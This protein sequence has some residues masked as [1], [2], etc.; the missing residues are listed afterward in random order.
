MKTNFRNTFKS[1]DR[2]EPKLSDG[3]VHSSQV[4]DLF[5]EDLKDMYWAEKALSN[6]IPKM[7]QN[8][9]SQELIDSL[10]DQLA[11]TQMQVLKV[12]R[13]FETLGIKTRDLDLNSKSG[14]KHEAD[15][16]ME[17]F[18]LGSAGDAELMMS[19]E[20]PEALSDSAY[21]PFPE[22]FGLRAA[23]SLLEST[24]QDDLDADLELVETD[25][26]VGYTG[27]RRF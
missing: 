25:E 18:E 19:E 6:A 26:I 21:H 17:P 2:Y 24:L 15:Y 27:S 14:L 5:E 10:T 13:V 20:C 9:K 16:I 3:Y 12:E 8:A 1:G 7:I 11:K 23:V 22:R 4:M